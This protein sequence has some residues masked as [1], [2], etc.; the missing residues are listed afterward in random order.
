[1]APQVQ[2]VYIEGNIASGKSTL[3]SHVIPLLVQRYASDPT[4]SILGVPEP[5]AQWTAMASSS[6]SDE[7]HNIFQ[8]HYTDPYRW[9]YLFQTT[10]LVTRVTT[11]N[12]AI[13][14][15]LTELVDSPVRTLIVVC[16][17]SLFVDRLVFVF[18]LHQAGLMQDVELAVYEKLWDEL[19]AT[20]H[21]GHIA[22]VVHWVRSPEICL[23]AIEQR[24]CEEEKLLELDYLE[25][26]HDLHEK[27]IEHPLAYGKTTTCTLD[28]EQYGDFRNNTDMH[29]PVVN[30]FVEL[31]QKADT[32]NG[33]SPKI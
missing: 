19:Y 30:A 2:Y 6:R 29:S 23:R 32:V 14:E 5:V 1:M 10:V 22:S 3:L 21:P 11:I 20:L 17:R 25:L 16:E 13:S 33:Q 9:S 24:G 7:T 12:K 27:V 28:A 26:V 31:L 18:L 4:V 8:L 15:R